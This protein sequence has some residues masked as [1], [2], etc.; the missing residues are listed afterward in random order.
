LILK[1][2]DIVV[3]DIPDPRGKK[4][5]HRHPAMVLR[6][7]AGVNAIYL[8]AI[9]TQFDALTIDRNWLPLPF[10]ADG[11]PETG[12]KEPCVLKC[13]WVVSF[14]ASNV[15]KKIGIMPVDIYERAVDII[16]ANVEKA[17]AS[18]EHRNQ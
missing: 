11:H 6:A 1:P 18:R 16:L 4:C 3:A 14:L 2:R 5:V 8:V 17:K 9:S 10:H 12:L 7:E 15:I 13:N